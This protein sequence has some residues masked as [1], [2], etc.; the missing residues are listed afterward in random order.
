MGTG[1]LVSLSLMGGSL[2]E[3]R[4]GRARQDDSV[5]P[6]S[7][8]EKIAQSMSVE[9]RK[10]WAQVLPD[11]KKVLEWLLV[12]DDLVQKKTELLVS[13]EALIE[14]MT[15]KNCDRSQFDVR[16]T[17]KVEQAIGPR[18]GASPA[19]PVQAAPAVRWTPSL[20]MSFC[21][22]ELFKRN[23]TIKD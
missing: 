10:E 17:S 4:S 1:I 21:K 2:Q 3:A 16:L 15:Q 7:H 23:R 13:S 14:A 6:S 12:P 5:L 11:Q 22:V 18:G 20:L 9:E 19:D 8:Y